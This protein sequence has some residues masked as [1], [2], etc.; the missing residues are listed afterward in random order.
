MCRDLLFTQGRSCCKSLKKTLTFTTM[1][2]ILT[3][4]FANIEA[5]LN[6][7]KKLNDDLPKSIG[8]WTGAGAIGVLALIGLTGG[9][10]L[11]AMPAAYGAIQ[12][13]KYATKGAITG[14]Q[15]HKT[16]QG[17]LDRKINSALRSLM[18][19]ITSQLSSGTLSNDEAIGAYYRLKYMD[20]D[21]EKEI[22]ELAKR[23]G[24]G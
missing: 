1:N 7:R 21:F 24:V 5:L 22:G 17:E 23:L 3:A 19:D 12:V 2:S 16:K 18:S 8:L 10:A 13:G 14:A 11:A 4:R 6:E 15:L 20:K 9:A